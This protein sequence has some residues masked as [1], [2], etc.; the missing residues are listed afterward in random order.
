[1]KNRIFITVAILGLAVS[2]ASFARKHPKKHK[3]VA[4]TTEQTTTKAK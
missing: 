1:M 2:S 4:A 3:K